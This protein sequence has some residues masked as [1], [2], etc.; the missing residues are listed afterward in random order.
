M[1]QD[2]GEKM[3]LKVN[4]SLLLQTL[5]CFVVLTTYGM[6]VSLLIRDQEG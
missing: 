6:H 1:L 5:I 2:K 4:A 3:T